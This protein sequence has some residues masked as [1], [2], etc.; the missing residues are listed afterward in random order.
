MIYTA[1]YRIKRES[2]RFRT[3]PV[4]APDAI[5]ATKE[6]IRLGGRKDMQLVGI[7]AQDGSFNETTWV[8]A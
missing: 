2:D 5:Q 3:Y 4:Y 8:F 6:A 7:R 1:T